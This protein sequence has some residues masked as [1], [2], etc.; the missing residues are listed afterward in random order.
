MRFGTFFSRQN[1]KLHTKNRQ[2]IIH[3]QRKKSL[4]IEHFPLILSIEYDVVSMNY[5]SPD[6]RFESFEIE[7]QVDL[8]EENILPC[9]FCLQQ[10]LGRWKYT[11][12]LLAFLGTSTI[13]TWQIQSYRHHTQTTLSCN[14]ITETS[15]DLESRNS[16]FVAN[17][18]FQTSSQLKSSNVQNE[19]K[20]SI[21]DAKAKNHN[22]DPSNNE[23]SIDSNN[24]LDKFEDID[25]ASIEPLDVSESSTR[26]DDTQQGTKY[27]LYFAESGWANQEI[28]MEHA[29]Y[30]AKAL[31]RTLILPPVLPHLG[32]GGLS[33]RDV[34]AME[35]DHFKTG[36]DPLNF[37]VRKLP[38]EKYISISKVLDLEYSFADV[39]TIDAKDFS[40]LYNTSTMTRWVIEY[41][42]SHFDT[43]WILNRSDLE[44]KFTAL[45]RQE[46]GK[47]R[48][49]NMTYR[50]IWKT[51]GSHT[52]DILVFLDGYKTVFDESSMNPS[53]QPRMS[54]RIRSVAQNLRAQWNVSAYAAI[55]IRG[56]D[57]WFAEELKLQETITTA[58]FR[59]SMQLTEWL[60]YHGESVKVVGLYVATDVNDLSNHT[61]MAR[62]I[63]KLV[64][65]IQNSNNTLVE[66]LWGRDLTQ[67]L[68]ALEGMRYAN[69]F[70]DI[71]MA[72]CAT[73]GF[74]GTEGSTFSLLIYDH[75]HES[76]C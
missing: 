53:F 22:L 8:P 32:K 1:G 20:N 50:D 23:T 52:E 69:V 66:L 45:T 6:E 47:T 63:P 76:S 19:K 10:R 46:Y 44:G 26:N 12:A 38:N 9:A 17:T 16:S 61:V 5:H 4:S 70:L 14:F 29:Y 67:D 74:V 68:Q 75:R 27:M 56:G 65:N 35:S 33:P 2:R 51:F 28:C 30:F 73:I 72:T 43:K 11:Y 60:R 37:Y 54:E 71:Q 34:F 64:N 31:N 42:Y 15:C 48:Q 25:V 58:M 3:V 49:L 40:S 41:N 57:G 13:I 59:I 55:H 36:V 62:E 7:Q 24:A 39:Q 21:S 18:I